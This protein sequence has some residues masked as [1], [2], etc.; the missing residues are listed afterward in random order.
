MEPRA[1]TGSQDVDGEDP[2][3]AEPTREASRMTKKP[4]T[5]SVRQFHALGQRVLKAMARRKRRGEGVHG[6]L[7][8]LGGTTRAQKIRLQ[9]S[10]H[11][12]KLYSRQQL[13]W[14]CGLGRD[15]GRPVSR[16]QVLQLIKVPDRRLRNNLAGRCARESWS[17]RKLEREIRRLG[18]RRRYGGARPARPQTVA[19]SL[20]ITERLTS[21]WLRWFEVLQAAAIPADKRMV[22]LAKLPPSI[23]NKMA[24]LKKL[25]DE[26]CT[27]VERHLTRTAKQFRKKSGPRSK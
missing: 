13:A 14:L 6:L 3:P 25:A 20:V 4:P 18:P 19:E 26:L 16:L 7:E 23:R 22:T 8:K 11:F 17:V 2:R 5:M 15:V 21:N 10:R 1:T 27:D 24:S 9:E 12:A